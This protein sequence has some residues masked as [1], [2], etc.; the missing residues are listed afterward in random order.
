MNIETI[1]RLCPEFCLLIDECSGGK[2]I[3]AFLVF[4]ALGEARQA[5]ESQK[6]I[7][8]AAIEWQ[9]YWADNIADRAGIDSRQGYLYDRVRRYRAKSPLKSMKEGG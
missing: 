1:K 6:D 7:V 4:K 2:N 8:D 3:P 5:L 9:S